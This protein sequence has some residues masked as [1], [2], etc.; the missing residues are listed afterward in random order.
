MALD[1]GAE[2]FE[3][4]PEQAAPEPSGGG[5]PRLRFA[6]RDQVAWR[7]VSLD[8]LLADDH[9]VRLVWDFVAGLDLTAL[10]ATIKAVDGRPG[11]PPAD[12]RILLALWVYATVKGIGSAREIARLCDEHIAFQWLC[13]GVG[14]NAKTLADFRVDHGA[15]LERLLVDSF[16]AL[17]RAGVASLDR[18]A[19]DGVRVRA[20]AGAASFRRHSTL[21]ECQREAEK[22]LADLRTQVNADPAA[23]NRKQ[24]ARQRT[25]EDRE[26]RV[27]AALAVSE[28]LHAQQEEQA[29]LE[30][31]REAKREARKAQQAAAQ[32]KKVEVEDA[33]GK[34]PRLSEPRAS[35]TD[36]QA[37]VMKM[38]DG[39]F[40]PAYNVQFATDTKSPAIAAVS[41]DTIGSDMGKMAPMNDALA[42]QYGE[43]PRQHLVDGGFVKFDDIETLA[44]NGVKVFA[45]VPKPRDASR[46]RHAP[47]D[48]DSPA[49]AAWRQRMGGD[50]AKKIYKQRAATAECANAQ[51][52]N[53]GLTQF[54]VRGLEKVKVVALWHALT[55]NMICSW[56]L[57]AT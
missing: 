41:V 18:M 45:P 40:R 27:R 4:L 33:A 2:L 31:E 3:G 42:S 57:I 11:H 5:L 23:A 55:H 46:D 20:S 48:G 9:R 21:Q 32:G 13:G 39:G 12:P 34:K 51:A 28:Q 25:A 26:R 30:A 17:V 43:R 8:G 15:V 44:G 37:R 54:V 38:A 22:A 14:M 7:P 53:R 50:E 6:E 47:Q 36:A 24:A 56:R 49:V 1:G 16:T 35:T 19:Q 10:H 52:R 29:R